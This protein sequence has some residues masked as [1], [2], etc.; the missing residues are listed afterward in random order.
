MKFT[1]ER[2]IPH[3]FEL[4]PMLQEHIIRYQFAKPYIQNAVVL[5]AGCG[6]GYGTHHLAT[7]GAQRVIGIDISPDA[8]SY[9]Q[10]RY[11]APNLSFQVMD[12]TAPTFGDEMFDTV[13]CLEVFE[14]IPNYEK[15][16]VESR[17]ILKPGGRLVIST[18]NKEIFSPDQ[19]EPINPWHIREFRKEE[20]E[21]LLRKHFDDV[22]FWSQTTEQFGI[23][24][25]I[26]FNLRLQRYFAT[27]HSLLARFLDGAYQTSMKLSMLPTKI[28]PGAL[29]KNPNKIEEPD[30]IPL[31]RTLYFV[32]VCLKN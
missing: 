23:V 32:A 28:I 18:P 10:K 30:R 7:E 16:L 5:D 25:F 22:Q 2:V 26:L 13:V 31:E 21:T 6:C 1:A 17:R 27:H 15:L 9:S 29:E 3:R 12:V 20:F 4:K 11:P 24:P 14:H 8:I 19:E